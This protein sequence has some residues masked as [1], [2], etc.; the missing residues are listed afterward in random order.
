MLPSL[1]KRDPVAHALHPVEQMRRQQHGDAAMLER[2]D[3][4][5][6]LDGRLR[7]EARGRL[8][9]DG[10]LRVL[11]QDLGEAEPLAHAA[12][13]R[14]H[15]LVGDVGQPDMRERGGDPLLAL[16]RRQADQPRRVAQIVGGGE[17]VVEADLVR[18][19]ADPALDRERLAHRIV[20]EHAA[21]VR[22][23]SRSARAASGWS[24]SC[25][26]HSDRAA[27]RSPRAPPRTRCP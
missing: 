22:P 27:R 9:E 1:N 16:G 12:R 3:D 13:E 15:P 5:Q 19:I 14:R 10:D 11:H 20:A 17:V 21:P 2:A 26:R 25:R 24:W 7:I 4:V 6:Q 23:R 18:Q 8:V